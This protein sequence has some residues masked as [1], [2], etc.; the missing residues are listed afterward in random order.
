M[1]FFKFNHTT[2]LWLTHPLSCVHTHDALSPPAFYTQM[3]RTARASALHR[4]VEWVPRLFRGFGPAL[5]RGG[6]II[7]HLALKGTIGVI[8]SFTS[9]LWT[10]KESASFKT[11]VL[12]LLRQWMFSRL[13]KDKLIAFE[14]KRFSY[15]LLCNI[16]LVKVTI[17]SVYQ[18]QSIPR[19]YNVQIIYWEQMLSAFF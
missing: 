14:S 8:S 16:K 1:K 17:V 18:C 6:S 3:F 10:W 2:R 7:R 4:L 13:Q 5:G 11:K 9:E 12:Q 15:L 19:K